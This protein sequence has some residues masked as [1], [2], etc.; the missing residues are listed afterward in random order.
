MVVIGLTGGIASGKSTISALLKKMG[1]KIIDADEIARE[2]VQPGSPTLLEIEQRF[3]SEL[4]NQDGSLNRKALGEKVFRDSSLV[5]ELNSIT[6]P[7]IKNLTENIIRDIYETDPEAIVVI[8]APLLLEA[9]ME[10]LVDEIWVAAVDEKIQVKRIM[11]RD[12]LSATEALAR[13]NNQL[14]LSEKIKKADRVIDTGCSWHETQ[15]IVKNYW[16]SITNKKG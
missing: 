4:I 2:I 6:H 9:N 14:P 1:A 16:T 8:D 15:L 13:I 10:S 7:R 11:E 12:R 3:G 5:K